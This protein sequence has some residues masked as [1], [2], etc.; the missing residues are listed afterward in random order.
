LKAT[1]RLFLIEWFPLFL[2][3][4]YIFAFYL[5]DQKYYS[6][7]IIFVVISAMIVLSSYIKNKIEPKRT[8]K[9][10]SREPENK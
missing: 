9:P 1:C 8:D 3:P 2:T 5:I 6:F 10:P 4:A 7:L